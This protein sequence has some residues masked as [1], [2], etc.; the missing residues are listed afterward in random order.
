MKRT[1]TIIYTMPCLFTCVASQ[2][3]YVSPTT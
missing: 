2:T 1:L 3:E